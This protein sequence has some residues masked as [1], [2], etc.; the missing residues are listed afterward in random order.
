MGLIKS[1]NAPLS[2]TPFSMQDI[3]QQ[4]KLVLL[5]A[6]KQADQL[7]AVA[8]A[9]ALQIKA[10]AKVEGM[11]DARIEGLAKGIK[12]GREAGRQEALN[13]ARAEFQYAVTAFT[14]AASELEASRAELN[15]GASEEVVRLAIAI[16]K[17]ITKRQ[18]AFDP[19]VL[20][21]NL[22]EAMKLVADASNVRIAIHPKQRKTLDEALPR[23]ELNFPALK[24]VELVDDA[25]LS[26]GDCRVFTQN[27]Q[28]DADL[29]VQLDRIVADLLPAP[30]QEVA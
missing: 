24:H 18:A 29:D 15:A 22:D 7:L 13:L 8:Q 5:R 6:Q 17:R 1:L 14:S 30:D 21:A 27:G 11:A 16:A 28:I 4:A 10:S 26:V 3:E 2:M 9:Q 20:L 23:L 25:S 12:E 19:Q